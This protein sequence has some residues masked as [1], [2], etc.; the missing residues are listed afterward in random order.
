VVLAAPPHQIDAHDQKGGGHRLIRE[1]SCFQS[2]FQ[3]NTSSVAL[4][5]FAGRIPRG[6]TQQHRTC[7]KADAGAQENKESS[8]NG[9]D[10]YRDNR[11]TRE[12]GEGEG[13]LSSRRVSLKTAV[14]DR[15]EPKPKTGP[16]PRGFG[17]REAAARDGRDASDI[18]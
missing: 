17:R 2:Y 4:L 8:E 5:Q 13:H 10:L 1:H 16:A 3:L 6:R 15:L 14:H 12:A 7:Q 11:S 18:G 9:L